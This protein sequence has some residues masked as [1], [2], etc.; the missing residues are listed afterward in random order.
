MATKETFQE[1]FVRLKFSPELKVNKRSLAWR[2]I[3]FN[4][5]WMKDVS[6][7]N[8]EISFTSE[9]NTKFSKDFIKNF[10]EKESSITD[11]EG[12]SVRFIA[13][14]VIEIKEEAEIYSL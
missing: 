5:F 9:F 12:V 2:Q 14:E 11:G 3:N 7:E 10:I 13:V 1:I 6:V 8:G 4:K